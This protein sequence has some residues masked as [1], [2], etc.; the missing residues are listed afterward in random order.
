MYFHFRNDLRWYQKTPIHE[1]QC[2]S[3]VDQVM[4]DLLFLY[5]TMM[6]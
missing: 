6:R 4:Q 5:P 1:D 2:E 3:G